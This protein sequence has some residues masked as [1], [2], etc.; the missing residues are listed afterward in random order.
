MRCHGVRFYGNKSGNFLINAAPIIA[1]AVLEL[2]EPT[3]WFG[4]LKYRYIGPRAL[5]EDGFFKSPAI[6]TVNAR[7]GYRWKEGWKFQLDVFNMLNS[8]SQLIAYGYGSLIGTDPLYR[9]CNGLLNVPVTADNCAVGRMDVHA[10]PIEPPAWRLTF[11]GPIDFDPSVKG[12]DL[13]EPFNLVKF[14]E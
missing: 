9:A 2:G 6:G 3:G 12:P 11:G 14:W 4:A 5:T 7:I 8:R 13:T 1:T 10:H